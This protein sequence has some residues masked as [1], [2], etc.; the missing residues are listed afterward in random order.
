MTSVPISP[1]ATLRPRRVPKRLKSPGSKTN[2]DFEAAGLKHQLEENL[3]LTLRSTDAFSGLETDDT[4]NSAQIDQRARTLR[5]VSTAGAEAG[6]EV[7]QL[8]VV[9]KNSNAFVR[10]GNRSGILR[11]RNLPNGGSNRPGTPQL[12]AV[13]PW[14]RTPYGQISV[15]FKILLPPFH[16]FSHSSIAFRL[17]PPPCR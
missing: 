7:V 9:A 16:G 4:L 13:M 17:N 8:Y 3:M 2:S 14:T 5:E 6:E 11:R 15:W 10:S 12:W 1:L